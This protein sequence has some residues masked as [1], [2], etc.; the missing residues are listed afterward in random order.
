MRS[1]SLLKG[2][3]VI[4][5]DGYDAPALIEIVASERIGWLPLVPGMIEGFAAA[6]RQQEVR[7]RGIRA[8]GAMADLVPRHQL[9]EITTLLGAPSR[10]QLR[11]HRD[12]PAA[13]DRRVDPDRRGADRSREA[14]E[15]VLR[16]AP[17]R[18]RRPGRARR[19][20]GRMRDP[21]PDPVQRLL[22]G[23]GGHAGDFRGG[24]FHMG[25]VFIGATTAD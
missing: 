10:Q 16:S 9:A 3:P 12:R 15:R 21:R 17:G 4:V 8:I 1:E 19:H 5:V 23:A 20:A 18:P 25:D 14:P 11:R 6:L 22:A 2:N 24:W 7:P 13:R